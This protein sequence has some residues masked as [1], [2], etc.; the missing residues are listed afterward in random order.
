[1]YNNYS[2]Y[3]YNGESNIMSTQFKYRKVRVDPKNEI[4][5]VDTLL[6]TSQPFKAISKTE[7][8]IS[9]KQCAT[10]TKR[11]IPYQELSK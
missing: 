3:N 6:K 2:R 11:K 10:L 4:K 9:K 5:M 8:Y 7:Y 1:M